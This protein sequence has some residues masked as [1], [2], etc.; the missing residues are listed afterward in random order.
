LKPAAPVDGAAPAEGLGRT[1]TFRKASAMP[2]LSREQMRR[3]HDVLQS[4]WRH[5]GVS[6]PVIAF[7]NARNEQLQGQPLQ[8]AVDSA[9]GLVRVE[10]L[11]WEMAYRA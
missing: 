5:F 1:R 8:I 10:K 2:H 7:L 9:E 4:A 6:A 11:L 3:Q